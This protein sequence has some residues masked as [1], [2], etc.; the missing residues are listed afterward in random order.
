MQE[1]DLRILRLIQLAGVNQVAN[2]ATTVRSCDDVCEKL[3]EI[4]DGI[5]HLGATSGQ[6]LKVKVSSMHFVVS[7]FETAGGQ[8]R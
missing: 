8:P 3:D 7:Y 6:Q 4:R 1:L 5:D 2:A